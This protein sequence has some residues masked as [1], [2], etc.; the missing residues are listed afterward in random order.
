MRNWHFKRSA[1]E[2]IYSSAFSRRSWVEHLPLKDDLVANG[3]VES[4]YA[5]TTAADLLGFIPVY[6]WLFL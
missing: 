5:S 6:E 2:Q 4:V 1:P 3:A